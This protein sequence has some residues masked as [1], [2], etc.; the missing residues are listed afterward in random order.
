MLPLLL[1]G[2]AWAR[3][4]SC[5]DLYAANFSA[6]IDDV[7]MAFANME[8][9]RGIGMVISAEPRIPCLI[10][11]PQQQDVARY[12]LRR[13]WAAALQMNQGDVDRWLGLAKA[14]DPSLPWPSYVPN[15]HPIR[16]QADERPTP[17]VQALDGEGLVVPDGGGVFLDGRFLTKPQGEPGVP[18]LLQVGDSSGYMAIAM[19]QDGLAFP[20]DLLGPP[21]D[22]DPVLPEWYGKPL[23]PGKSPKPPK[24][25]R[26]KRPW[27]E[28]RLTNL[29]RGMG[30]ALVGASLWGSALLARSAYDNHPTDALFVATDVGTVGALA[31]GGVAITFTSLALFGK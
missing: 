22:T 30:F 21:L 5:P 24:P 20:D 1:L 25:A 27:T 12:A 13:A 17:V 2:A 11:V 8:V 31:S 28:P 7:D 16:D 19:W 9:E 23:T 18:H 3:D 14:L 15:G 4:P 26:E 6:L 10:D 29:E